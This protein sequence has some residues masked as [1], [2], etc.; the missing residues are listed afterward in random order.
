MELVLYEKTNS[1]A[2]QSGNRAIVATNALEK[3]M[4]SN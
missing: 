1:L 4:A 3:V 2:E